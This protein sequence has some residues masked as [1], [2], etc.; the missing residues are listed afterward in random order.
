MNTKAD[1]NIDFANKAITSTAQYTADGNYLTNQTD[2]S[3]ISTNYTYEDETDR[4]HLT[5][6]TGKLSRL[7]MFMKTAI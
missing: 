4:Q 2:S 1:S 5:Y 7:N 6:I 3:G